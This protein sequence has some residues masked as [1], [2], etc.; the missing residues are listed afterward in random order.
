MRKLLLQV[1][2]FT[3]VGA[4]LMGVVM[5]SFKE[6]KTKKVATVVYGVL[7]QDSGNHR[8]YITASPISTTSGSCGLASYPCRISFEEGD[9]TIQGD[10]ANGWYVDDD[11]D[12]TTSGNG[13]YA[14]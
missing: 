5:M 7:S 10:A 6:D 9:V 2:T 11:A 13:P 12:F 1:N 3:V 8:L 4:L 14:N